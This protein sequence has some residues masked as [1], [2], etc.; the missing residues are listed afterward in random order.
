[1]SNL[2]SK[3]LLLPV[4]SSPFSHVNP[5]Y[6]LSNI[7][8]EVVSLSLSIVLE[9][10]DFIL[11]ARGTTG[12]A[13]RPATFAFTSNCSWLTVLDE[14]SLALS[15]RSIF[16]DGRTVCEFTLT[17][18][19]FLNVESD[20]VRRVVALSA[21]DFDVWTSIV[22]PPTGVWTSTEVRC[23]ASIVFWLH[24]CSCFARVQQ[25]VLCGRV[26]W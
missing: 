23:S 24:C 16:D 22:G 5:H 7:S 21:S 11:D 25:S 14:A 10:N 12:L 3:H 19:N 15:P 20:P 18:T 17:V 13:G 9:C 8:R 2:R 6:I 26:L 4:Y 1:M